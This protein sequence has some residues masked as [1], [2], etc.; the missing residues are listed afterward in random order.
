MCCSARGRRGIDE[1]DEGSV[2]AKGKETLAK[3]CKGYRDA[4]LGSEDDGRVPEHRVDE[5]RGGTVDELTQALDYSQ[6]ADRVMSEDVE[7]SRSCWSVVRGRHTVG[8]PTQ[9]IAD[10]SISEQ[11]QNERER[12]ERQATHQYSYD[13]PTPTP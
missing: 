11:S 2:V 10:G 4:S 3:T 12:E 13:A 5:E 6:S 1:G 9:P 8:K 7:T